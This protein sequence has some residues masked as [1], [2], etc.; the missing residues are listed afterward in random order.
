MKRSEF[1]RLLMSK[2]PNEDPEVDIVGDGICI[3][4]VRFEKKYGINRVVIETPF[5]LDEL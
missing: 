5:E 4:G 1:V 2:M 3:E